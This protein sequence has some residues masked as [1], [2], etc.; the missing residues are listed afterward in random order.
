MWGSVLLPLITSSNLH[1]VAGMSP[2]KNPSLAALTH[3]HV[4]S[5]RGDRTVAKEA[6]D[7]P[8]VDAILEEQGRDGMS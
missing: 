2:G 6:L 5:G 8:Q 7:V 4:D 3:L 1:L